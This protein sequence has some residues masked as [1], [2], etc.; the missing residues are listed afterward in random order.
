[1]P[2]WEKIIL[3]FA[4]LALG[5]F[6]KAVRRLNNEEPFFLNDLALGSPVMLLSLSKVVSDLIEGFHSRLVS[7]SEAQT[8]MQAAEQRVLWLLGVVVL[9]VFSL[10][11]D[12]YRWLRSRIGTGKPGDRTLSDVLIQDL[13]AFAVLLGYFTTTT[14]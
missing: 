14:K 9:P 11:N 7:L 3:T 4:F 12:R 2:L 13:L 6:S 5:Y 10:M 1:M 8:S